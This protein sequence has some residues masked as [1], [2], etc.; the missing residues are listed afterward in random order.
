[1][2]WTE[3]PPAFSEATETISDLINFNV[4][5]PDA[6]NQPHPLET[7]ASTHIA[8][9]PYE[10]DPYPIKDTVP[11]RPPLAYVDVYVD[12]FIKACQGWSNVLR[13]RR[14]TFDNINSV[15]RPNDSLDTNRKQPISERKLLKGDDIWKTQK[16]ILGWFINTVSMTASLP[17]HIQIQAIDL[18]TKMFSC[19]RA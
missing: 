18:L 12:Y 19:R 14:S 1:M 3:Y 13:V 10:P 7:L 5:S 4:E 6:I 16:T 8:L 11:L 17:P 9:Y 2:G 15:F